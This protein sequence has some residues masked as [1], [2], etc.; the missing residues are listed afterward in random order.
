MNYE[1][2]ALSEN[3][4]VCGRETKKNKNKNTATKGTMAGLA[5]SIK[6][7]CALDDSESIRI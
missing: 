6:G 1:Q 7:I 5:S 4:A 2:S 3:S